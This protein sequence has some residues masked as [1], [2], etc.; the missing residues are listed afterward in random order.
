MQRERVIAL[1]AVLEVHVL[2]LALQL[3]LTVVP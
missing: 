3:V 2:D 1:G